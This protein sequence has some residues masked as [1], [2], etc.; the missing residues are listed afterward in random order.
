M[1]R[2]IWGAGLSVMA[3]L[4]LFS[5]SK[6]PIEEITVE[7]AALA[8]ESQRIIKDQ[9]IVILSKKPVKQDPRAA[10]ALEAISKEVGNMK[11]ARVRAKFRHSLTGFSANLSKGQ[12]KKLEKD[13]RV[14]SITPD[15]IIELEAVS[16]AVP[17]TVQEYPIWNLDRIDQRTIKMD[18]AYTHTATGAGV[19]AYIIDSGIRYSHSE[20]SDRA[21]LGIDLVAAYPEDWDVNEPKVD[22]GDDCG[23]HGTHVAGTVGGE[24]Y[25]VAKDVN[26]ISVKVFSCAGISSESRV[27]SAIEWVTA[28]AAKEENAGRPA[29]VNMSLG[30]APHGA[31]ETAVENSIATGINYVVAAGNSNT[32]ACDFAPARVPGALT[33][34]ASD[35]SNWRAYFSNYGDCVDLYAPGVNITSAGIADDTATINKN[36]TSM[37]APHVTGLV[38]LYLETHPDATPEEVH[39]AVVENATPNVIEDVPSGTTNLAYTHWGR[40]EFTAPEPPD[41]NLRVYGIES[42]PRS[43]IYL[44]WD[45]TESPYYLEV[46]KNGELERTT[47]NSG[48]LE[49]ETKKNSRDVYQIC[50]FFYENCSEVVSPNF[51]DLEGFKPNVKPTASFVYT[52]NGMEVSFTDTSTDVDGSIVEWTWVMGDGSRDLRVQNP[53]YTYSQPGTYEVILFAFDN[54]ME[55]NYYRQLITI[56]GEGVEAPPTADFSYQTDGLSVQLQD[57]SSDIGGAVESWQWDFGDGNSSTLQ[58]PQHTYSEAGV[59]TISLLVKDNQ[60]ETASLS[61]EVRVEVEIPSAIKLSA[62]GS[63]AKGEWQADLEWTTDGISGMVD[64]YRDGNLIATVANSGTYRDDTDRKGGGELTYVVCESGSRV[65]CSNEVRLQF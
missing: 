62:I 49:L 53:T 56:T 12:L 27:M 24:L 39:A 4:L 20:F 64:I 51:D 48:Q 47:R 40:S 37:A 14:V 58:H 13:P 7:T 10:V 23:G 15:R 31:L 50:E 21:K 8:V 41:M 52:V 63:K 33:V 34:G 22:P 60:G 3:L 18:R 19:D 28:E 5:C 38:A 46:Y 44:V 1:R 35:V 55:Q 2:A 17:V 29:V 43:K 54:L 32:L 26:L 57:H 59:Y 65:S 11:G 61:R 6:E 16:D 45:P 42:G 25:G 36:G 30:G 9:Y